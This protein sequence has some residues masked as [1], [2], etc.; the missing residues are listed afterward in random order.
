[1]P[2]ASTT[3]SVSPEE[4]SP[5]EASASA[6]SR[7][8]PS[9]S[10]RPPFLP[11]VDRSSSWGTAEGRAG[12]RR[13][14]R[15][16][17]I[18]RRDDA[19]GCARGPTARRTDDDVVDIARHRRVLRDVADGQ[20]YPRGRTAGAVAAF[21][22]DDANLAR[23]A[24]Q[25]GETMRRIRQFGTDPRLFPSPPP[26]TPARNERV[27]PRLQARH[28]R[29]EAHPALPD[30]TTN[31]ASSQPTPFSPLP[32]HFCVRSRTPGAGPARIRVVPPPVHG[33][34]RMNSSKS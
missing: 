28:Y 18:A 13:R 10:P 12:T 22:V 32:V 17:R 27:Y 23:G 20:S 1:M 16:A 3:E 19:R 14:A 9:M 25:G 11:S 6:R 8:P 31:S 29:A 26:R 34:I 30:R 33:G 2:S 5:V 15:G 4:A 21:A 7:V 24:P